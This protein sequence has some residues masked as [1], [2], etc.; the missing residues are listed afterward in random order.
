VPPRQY[1]AVAERANRQCEYCLAPEEFFNS[2][3]EVEHLVPRARG[4]G[5]DLANLALACRNCNGAKLARLQL[6]DPQTNEPV[7]IFNPRLDRWS[8][9]F[10]FRLTDRGVE[11]GGKTAIGRATAEHL[12]MN[13]VKAVEARTLWFHFYSR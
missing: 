3:F 2:P 9:H 7:R 1:R 11:I 5:H 4:G 6:R 10:I 13:S 12:N 8:E